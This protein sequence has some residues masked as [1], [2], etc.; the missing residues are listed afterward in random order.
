M[1]RDPIL[2]RC[3]TAPHKGTQILDIEKARKPRFHAVF[4]AK[5]GIGVTGFEPTTPLNKWL[6]KEEN[7]D[8]SPFRPTSCPTRA[9]AGES[10]A[11]YMGKSP[12]PG[13]P[14]SCRDFYALLASCWASSMRFFAIS[15]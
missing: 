1:G 11:P 8:P 3:P 14:P 6:K 9:G 15:K 13:S 7:G 10:P 12:T 4:R 5:I 2:K